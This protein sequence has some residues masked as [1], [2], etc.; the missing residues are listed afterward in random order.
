MATE[1]SARFLLGR[2]RTR[3]PQILNNV[4]QFKF[5]G[6]REHVVPYEVVHDFTGHNGIDPFLTIR[7]TRG[8][9]ACRSVVLLRLFL[10]LQLRKHASCVCAALANMVGTGNKNL[11]LREHSDANCAE[12]RF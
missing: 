3:F 12:C 2:F 10:R 9:V 5:E 1:D 4:F 7:T 11:R 8:G 6:T